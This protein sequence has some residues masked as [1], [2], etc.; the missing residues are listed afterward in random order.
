MPAPSNGRERCVMAIERLLDGLLATGILVMAVSMAWQVIGRYA[1][2]RAPGWSE[3]LCR[4]LMLWVTML[5]SA[6]VVR[7]G[8]HLTVTALLDVLPPAACSLLLALRDALMVATC[9]LLAWQGWLFA[10]LN[11]DQ[12]SAAMEIAMTWPYAAIPVGAAL[13]LVMVVA[14]RVLGGPFLMQSED[15]EGVL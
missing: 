9:G 5:G 1:F 11:G 3:E 2:G 12:D 15:G 4:F 7:R 14:A 6:A 8:G 10:E 13:I